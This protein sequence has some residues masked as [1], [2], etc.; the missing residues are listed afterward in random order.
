MPFRPDAA[1]AFAPYNLVLFSSRTNTF[2]LSVPLN[3]E[4]LWTNA[5]DRYAN[6]YRVSNS[7]SCAF[8]AA[9]FSADGKRLYVN[10]FVSGAPAR[11]I[12]RFNVQR[13]LKAEGVQLTGDHEVSTSGRGTPVALAVAT[14]PY[15]QDGANRRDV[16]YYVTDDGRIYAVDMEPSGSVSGE[17]FSQ[18]GETLS[19]ANGGARIAVTGLAAG[20]PHLV[21]ATAQTSPR[22]ALVRVYELNPVGGYLSASKTLASFDADQLDN[23]GLAD[24][25]GTGIG[26][27]ASDDDGTLVHVGA[28]GPA[29]ALK[30]GE[31][32]AVDWTVRNGSFAL[33]PG[34]DAGTYTNFAWQS[35]EWTFESSDPTTYKLAFVLTNGVRMVDAPA[36]VTSYGHA[37]APGLRTLD[38]Q[39]LPALLFTEDSYRVVGGGTIGVF[40]DFRTGY[41]NPGERVSGKVEAVKE[42]W[43]LMRLEFGGKPVAVDAEGRFDCEVTDSNLLTAFFAPADAWWQDP[44]RRTTVTNVLET[45]NANDVPAAVDEVGGWYVRGNGSRSGLTAWRLDA[46][47]NAVNPQLAASLHDSSVWPGLTMQSAA[48]T[49]AVKPGQ[50]VV[51]GLS[52]ISAGGASAA[53][54]YSLGVGAAWPG[55]CDVVSVGDM[56]NFEAWAGGTAGGLYGYSQGFVTRYDASGDAFVR[57][58]A[59]VPFALGPKIFAAAVAGRDV[60]YG[61][62]ATNLVAMD[63]ATGAVV[64]NALALADGFAGLLGVSPA[65]A[66]TSSPRLLVAYSTFTDACRVAVVPL[67]SDGLGAASPAPLADVSLAGFLGADPQVCALACLNDETRAFVPLNRNRT[68]VL[69]KKPAEVFAE[70]CV[71]DE[72]GAVIVPEDRSHSVALG[73]SLEFELAAPE[74]R[75]FSDLIVDGVRDASFRTVSNYVYA[76]ASQKGYVRVTLV[77][78]P[79]QSIVQTLVG[80]VFAE[81]A[82]ATNR[83]ALGESFRATYTPR[84]GYYVSGILTNGAPYAFTATPGFS[85]TLDTGALGAGVQVTVVASRLRKAAQHPW[86]ENPVVVHVHEPAFKASGAFHMAGDGDFVAAGGRADEPASVLDVSA[87]EDADGGFSVVTNL[88]A[89]GSKYGAGVSAAL[90]RA[91][92]GRQTGNLSLAVPLVGEDGPFQIGNEDADSCMPVQFAFSTD[93]RKVYAVANSPVPYFYAFTV[94]DALS[95]DGV[96]LKNSSTVGGFGSGKNVCGIAYARVGAGAREHLY[97]ALSDSSVMVKDLASPTEAAIGLLDAGAARL[98]LANASMSVCQ[99]QDGIPHLAIA[100]AADGASAL[101]V[102]RM[103]ADG[104]TAEAAPVLSLDAEHLAAMGIGDTTTSFATS[105]YGLEGGSAAILGWGG[106][107]YAVKYVAPIEVTYAV[108]NGSGDRADQ[109]F[110]VKSWFTDDEKRISFTAQPG[111]ILKKVTV[112]GEPTPFTYGAASFD[113]LPGNDA[114]QHVEVVFLPPACIPEPVGVAYEGVDEEARHVFALPEADG[115]EVTV[116]TNGVPLAPDAGYVVEDG[117]LLAGPFGTLRSDVHLVVSATPPRAPVAKPWHAAPTWFNTYLL[118]PAPG[119]VG[120]ADAAHETGANWSLAAT[121]DYLIDVA[122][123]GRGGAT[124]FRFGDV[125]E[126]Q[127]K[128]VWQIAY[129]DALFGGGPLGGA[130]ACKPINVA[131]VGTTNGEYAV[132]LPLELGAG[133]VL[134]NAHVFRITAVQEDGVTPTNTPV[135]FAFSSDGTRLFGVAPFFTGVN[136]YRVVGGLKSAGAN[137]VLVQN[138]PFRDDSSNPRSA[139]AFAYAEIPNVGMSSTDH[140]AFVTDSDGSLYRVSLE[141]DFTSHHCNAETNGVDITLYG[142]R[143]QLAVAGV[144]A[145]N[146]HLY[147]FFGPKVDASPGSHALMLYDVAQPEDDYKI[148]GKRVFSVSDV[149]SWT[150]STSSS[151]AKYR[152]G[153]FCAMAVP[154]DERSFA[155]AVN[156][157]REERNQA[158]FMVRTVPDWTLAFSVVN[159]KC[160]VEGMTASTGEAV[161]KT[162]S[163]TARFTCTEDYYLESYAVDDVPQPVSTVPP[164]RVLD[165]PVN[166]YNGRRHRV[167]VRFEKR[168]INLQL[169]GG[170]TAEELEDRSYYVTLP[171]DCPWEIRENGKLVDPD[172]ATNVADNVV[173]YTPDTEVAVLNAVFAFYKPRPEIDESERWYAAGTALR[174]SHQPTEQ[175]HL[176]EYSQRHFAGVN[177]A[178]DANGSYLLDVAGWAMGGA[179]LYGVENLETGKVEAVGGT[180]GAEWQIDYATQLLEGNEYRYAQFNGGVV[181]KALGVAA[182]AVHDA[183]ILP[184]NSEVMLSMPL[185]LAGG[186]L[187]NRNVFRITAFKPDD[188][189]TFVKTPRSGAFTENGAFLWGVSD[190]FEGVYKYEVIDGLKS[191]GQKLKLVDVIPLTTGSEPSQ[192]SAN[193]A[194]AVLNDKEIAFVL[195]TNCVV[196]AVNLTDRTVSDTGVRGGSWHDQLAIAGVGKGIPHLYLARAAVTNVAYTGNSLLT[197]YDVDAETLALSLKE[198]YTPQRVADWC[199]FEDVDYSWS[200]Y[201]CAIAVP[202]NEKSLF[203]TWNF[204]NEP[205]RQRRYVVQKSQ[206]ATLMLSC[207][208]GVSSFSVVTS[209]N[210]DPTPAAPEMEI[211]VRPYTRVSFASYSPASGADAGVRMMRVGA[212]LVDGD[213][214][215]VTQTNGVWTVGSPAT[216]RF[217]AGDCASSPDTTAADIVQAVTQSPSGQDLTDAEKGAVEANVAAAVSAVGGQRAAQ[218]LEDAGW[219]ASSGK[220]LTAADVAAAKDVDL[221]ALLGTE[222]L[223]S[224]GVVATITQAIETEDAHGEPQLAFTFVVEDGAG[225]GALALTAAD[226]AAVVRNFVRKSETLGADEAWNAPETDDLDVS[227]S[228]DRK[229][230]TVSVKLGGSAQGFYK[231][232]LK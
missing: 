74:G 175:G 35:H 51:T 203:M 50:W 88:P 118:N 229:S 39:F 223:L 133:E 5:V 132:S 124:L 183:S 89:G 187:N 160:F 38:V 1:T 146:L 44:F 54:R 155:F 84:T 70:T 94:A 41:V 99:A 130:A 207:G 195:G 182:I 7:A 36:G 19:P 27:F 194:Y 10:R 205:R 120:D 231:L 173:H 33:D 200:Y 166:E 108:T 168:V 208:P 111:N 22:A 191:A 211:S 81:P 109:P 174:W 140:L 73:D 37:V 171:E 167:T 100:S 184:T 112:N 57:E 190:G 185:D 17:T 147:A 9:A 32:Q 123:G 162:G 93:A 30:Y 152:E 159:G 56:G 186:E 204:A 105:V 197:L 217:G 170:V 176:G 137:L 95:S 209:E 127:G 68:V 216:L 115:L 201:T 150:M 67:V 72:N 122:G 143:L 154:D 75:L 92:F 199:G 15:A 119:Y 107:F 52:G 98:S 77:A 117:K 157:T 45:S 13:G 40:T 34:K 65:G 25:S 49:L 78:K 126:K 221:A 61:L 64:T 62:S 142:E 85:V 213:A 82:H 79:A 228:G 181:S 177:W 198:S 43:K 139:A 46:F 90:N 134:D 6:A 12:V 141:G 212:E 53:M 69:E 102:F 110:V 156:S 169:V 138:H 28:E 24:P 210:P 219:G 206:P 179:S 172:R 226:V 66:D 136:E 148:L 232:I 153:G 23:V 215:R 31:P 18:I 48:T 131:L 4:P 97:V 224:T 106:N 164:I 42:G 87:V 63:S 151:A 104:R 11:A 103:D 14:L 135:R 180:A 220:A 58:G 225:N 222:V 8:N 55:D 80:P 145:T 101:E 227:L 83:V 3:G 2:A 214:T 21:V 116:Y 96:L 188:G 230:A 26:L 16:V 76:A 60:L 149:L 71:L 47:T 178:M 59:P 144:A 193:M 91:I 158:R 161:V 29:V 202:D 218:W 121:Q 189:K 86:W 114:T 125:E 20:T 129:S 113:Y 196:Y 192:P 163:A 165:V 128:P